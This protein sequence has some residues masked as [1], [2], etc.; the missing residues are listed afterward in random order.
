VSPNPPG[1]LTVQQRWSQAFLA[2]YASPD[3]MLVSGQGSWVRDDAG[4]GYLDLIGGIA[5]TS[6]G[7]AHPKVVEAVARQVGTLAHTSNL[8]AHPGALELAER[9]QGWIPAPSRVFLCNDG[10]T[11][12]EAALK[13]AR[14]H[15]RRLDPTGACLEVVAAVGGFHGRTFGALAVTGQPDKQAPFAPL[16]GPVSFV[17]FGDLDA[18]AAAIV[19]GRT[20]AVILE[21]IQGEG[22]VVVPPEGYLAAVRALCDDAGALLIV[23]EVQ[24]GAARTGP[25]L[26]SVGAGVL[27]DVVTL[28][29]GLGGGLPIGACLAVGDAA[30]LFQPGDHGSTFG[31]NPVSTAASLAVMEVLEELDAPRRVVEAGQRFSGAVDRLADPRIVGTR[32]AGLLQAVVIDG[33]PAAAVQAAARSAGFLVNAVRPD[34]IR[35]APP[36]TISDDEL[37][38]FVAALPDLLDRA[39]TQS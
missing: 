38:R 34:A 8:F 3:L 23:D 2:N 14:K 21:P 28:A 39:G 13:L 4:K 26:A 22:G 24:T 19:R 30:T 5:V 35:I 18:M 33:P 32:G 37:D 15:G 16:P 1:A 9:L 7:H 29:K 6:V 27:P 36:L 17:P 25:W 11:A 10:A 31:G 20:A 12:N